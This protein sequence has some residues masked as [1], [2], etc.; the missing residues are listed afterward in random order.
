VRARGPSPAGADNDL[1]VRRSLDEHV[2][3]CRIHEFA[4]FS[5]LGIKADPHTNRVRT[6]W[7]VRAQQT[8]FT[9]NHVEQPCRGPRRKGYI[10]DPPHRGAR[11]GLVELAINRCPLVDGVDRPCPD[12]G[13]MAG[14]A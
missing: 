5:W 6:D 3:L 7:L 10:A 4:M 12:R 11:R 1:R 8:G 14:R 9:A 2:E 13:A